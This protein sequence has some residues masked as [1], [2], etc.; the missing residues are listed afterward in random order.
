MTGIQAALY[1]GRTRL[2]PLPLAYYWPL[3][4]AFPVTLS[5]SPSPAGCRQQRGRS[6]LSPYL[7]LYS[8]LFRMIPPGGTGHLGVLAAL[9]SILAFVG[10]VQSCPPPGSRFVFRD[11]FLRIDSEPGLS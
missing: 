3:T 10:L 2:W 9:A 11:G 1:I 8:P 5:L 7:S 4:F 6:L